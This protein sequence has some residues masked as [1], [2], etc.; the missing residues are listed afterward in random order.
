MNGWVKIHRKFL[1]WEWYQKSE[2][3]HLFLYL[4]LSANHED[5]KWQ[6][7]EVKRGQLITGRNSISKN[8]GISSQTVR[9]C[10]IHLKSTNEIT[11]KPTNKFSIITVVKYNEY[12][13]DDKKSTNKPTNKPTN[14]QPTTNQQLTTNKKNKNDKK[15]KEEK[16]R[17]DFGK[18]NEL[19]DKLLKDKII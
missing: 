6:G 3:V 15:N 10:L 5:G 16:K 7:I 12:Q 13:C 19:R 8:T 2:M 11:I 18:L 1:K 9:T 17:V 4:L 14:N